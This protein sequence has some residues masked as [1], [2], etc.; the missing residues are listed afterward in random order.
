MK[1][2]SGAGLGLHILEVEITNRCNL[3][4]KH[5][6]NRDYQIQDLPLQDIKELIDLA[7]KNKVSKFVFSGG[8]AAL[9]PK[10]TEISK[11]LKT[12]QGETKFIVQSNGYIANV[13]I[14][15]I[16]AFNVVHLSFEIDDDCGVR[17][18]SIQDTTSLAKRLMQS[19]IYTY[20]FATVHTGNIGHIDRLVSLANNCGIDIGFNLCLSVKHHDN[21]SLSETQRIAVIRKLHDLYQQ[22]KILRFSSPFVSILENKKS[23]P[24]NGNKGGCTAG[25]AACVVLPNG[26]VCPCPFFRIKAG[27]VYEEP[28]EKIWM[29]SDTFKELR[30]RYLFDEP[31]GSCEFLSYC[32]GCRAR[33]FKETGKLTG[34]D[35][36]CVKHKL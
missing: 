7:Q 15:I 6:Y 17:K 20:F 33:A 34:A 36:E 27:N 19:G 13:P 21:L 2:I 26:D 32:S 11:Y 1:K 30:K 18:I 35:P 5:C 8:E 14:E 22:K 23:I 24:Y 31:C 3:N 16:K 25:I 4:C 10:F 9:H 12:I 28:F 29:E